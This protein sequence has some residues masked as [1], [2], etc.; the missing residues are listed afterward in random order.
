MGNLKYDYDIFI[1][2]K[3]MDLRTCTWGQPLLNMNR[4]DVI[5]VKMV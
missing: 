1:R 5:I 3:D 2:S 4:Y